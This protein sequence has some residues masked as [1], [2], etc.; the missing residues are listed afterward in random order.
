VLG[1]AYGAANLVGAIAGW[2]LLVRRVGSLDGWA[3]ARSLARM[4]LAT[5]PGLV[6]VVLVMLL[7]GRFLHNPSAGYGLFVSLIGGSGAVAL[8]ALFARKL[9]V[10][11]FGFLMRTI[12]G[13]FGSTGTRH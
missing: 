9:R 10:A 7:A 11:E 1:V 8:Y 13:R 2:I 3:V 5:V 6:F 12:A 4:H